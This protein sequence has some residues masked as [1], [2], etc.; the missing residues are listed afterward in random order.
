MEVTSPRV[1]MRHLRKDRICSAG[2]RS[3]WTRHGLDWSD[4][5]TNGIDGQV[6]LDT[7]D[8]RAVRVVGIA[9]EEQ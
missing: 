8:P 3:F 5:V 7:R 9:R 6:L 1:Y 4:F 2:A